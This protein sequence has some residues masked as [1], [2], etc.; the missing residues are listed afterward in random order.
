MNHTHRQRKIEQDLNWLG[1]CHC[2]INKG[3]HVLINFHRDPNA[4]LLGQKRDSILKDS[5]IWAGLSFKENWSHDYSSST[6]KFISLAS[7]CI[8]HYYTYRYLKQWNRKQQTVKHNNCHLY[9]YS[10]KCLF[11][12][13]MFLRVWNIVNWESIVDGFMFHHKIV[14]LFAVHHFHLLK[15]TLKMMMKCSI[16]KK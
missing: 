12:V 5:V 8:I 9:H 10:K 11:D 13:L 6:Q 2:L 7:I 3:T 4:I 16:G 15:S 14:Q 1:R